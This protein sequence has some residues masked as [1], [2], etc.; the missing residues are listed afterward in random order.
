MFAS[1]TTSALTSMRMTKTEP[2][3]AGAGEMMMILRLQPL[4]HDSV[5][6]KVDTLQIESIFVLLSVMYEHL[7]PSST[8]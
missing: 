1:S 6:L 5:F 2:S 7:S 3:A 4:S 8:R